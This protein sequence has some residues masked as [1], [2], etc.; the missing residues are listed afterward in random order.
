[1]S[2]CS[3][4][5]SR[6][7]FFT[8]QAHG[9]ISL[10]GG[11][12]CAGV[13]GSAICTWPKYIVATRNNRGSIGQAM[14]PPPPRPPFSM[15]GIIDA[16]RRYSN[17]TGHDDDT[18]ISCTTLR[19]DSMSTSSAGSC[20]FYSCCVVVFQWPLRMRRVSSI[21]SEIKI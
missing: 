10:A 2:D 1:M 7:F 11:Q 6:P 5:T 18:V 17:D 21:K 8:V 9:D 19:S 15:D 16:R 13:C 12:V 14:L 4:S 20:F 3:H